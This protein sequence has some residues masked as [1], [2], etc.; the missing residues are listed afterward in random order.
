M[1]CVFRELLRWELR[2]VCCGGL[3]ILPSWARRQVAQWTTENGRVDVARLRRGK[4]LCKVELLDRIDVQQAVETLESGEW[5]PLS[6]TMDSRF[7]GLSMESESCRGRA[8]LSG[9][10]VKACSIHFNFQITPLTFSKIMKTLLC[11]FCFWS[12]VWH[13]SPQ[14]IF[15]TAFLPFGKECT[16]NTIGLI[17]LAHVK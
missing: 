1:I 7:N 5:S 4:M 3:S 6:S 17:C 2:R 11:L 12:N 8:S 10:S 9:P 13:F 16:M 15:L 14:K